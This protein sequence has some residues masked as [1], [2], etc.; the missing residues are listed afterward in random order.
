MGLPLTYQGVFT[1]GFSRDAACNGEATPNRQ[2]S[3]TPPHALKQTRLLAVHPNRLLA[4][5]R[6]AQE[7]PAVPLIE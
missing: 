7:R 3:H 1:Q 4:G 5:I 2:A 6:H